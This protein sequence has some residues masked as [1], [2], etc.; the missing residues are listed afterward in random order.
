[1]LNDMDLLDEFDITDSEIKKLTLLMD[2]DD[3]T[4][5][6]NK[7]ASIDNLLDC[8]DVRIIRMLAK[9]LHVGMD[10]DRSSTCYQPTIFNCSSKTPFFWEL[11][12]R[13]MWL[14]SKTR[15]EMK[16]STILDYEKVIHVL[17][18]QVK[19]VLEEK[20][21]DFKTLTERMVETNYEKV[22]EIWQREKKEELRS[23]LDTN[24]SVQVL[25]RRF[26]K[27]NQE[28]IF[29]QRMIFVKAGTMFPKFNEKV[30]KINGNFIAKLSTSGRDVLICD[31]NAITKVAG[32][33]ATYSLSS[34]T[35]VVEGKACPHVINNSV[36][37]PHLAFSLLIN[38]E[39][40]INFKAPDK[41][42]A[43][44]WLDAFNLLLN[45]DNRSEYYKNELSELVEMDLVL[46]LMDLQN[47]TIPKRPPP[48]PKPPF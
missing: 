1:M 15:R 47:V 38:N 22:V 7:C 23:V 11:F 42:T 37:E 39:I 43:S 31:F 46:H 16:A 41:K 32:A 48:V 28:L 13:T 34:I 36:K 14:L 6:K 33:T 40:W 3:E 20:P 35:H 24:P 9:L 30:S 19:L 25:K 17:T 5:A 44:Y 29:E 12:S 26:A 10:P 4:A 18:K 21:L 8:D 27:Q 2:F 45:K